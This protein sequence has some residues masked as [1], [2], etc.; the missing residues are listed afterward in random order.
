MTRRVRVLCA[1][2]VSAFLAVSLPAG[3][4]PSSPEELAAAVAR[5]GIVL[6]TVDWHGWVRD[7]QTGEVF[8]GSEG[9]TVKVTCSGA[10]IDPDGYVATASHCVHTGP[11]GGAGVL[12]D[13]ALT[14]LAKA[15]RVGDP[16]KAKQTLTDHAVAE[17]GAPDRPVDRQIQ[18][19]R[20]VPD[21]NGRKRDVAP[22][23][24]ADLVAPEDGDVAVLKVARSRLPAVQLRPDA[25]PVGT[26]VLAIGYPGSV[27]QATDPNLEPSNK[28]GQISA[29]R[30]QQGR[31][32]Y[33]FSAAATHGMSGGPVVDTQGRIVGL[34]SQASP[35]ETQS[36]NFAS[37]SST[38]LDVLHGKGIDVETSPADKDYRT[39]LDR[40]FDGDY[41][42]AVASFDKALAG[43]PSHTQAA[44][45]RRKA[46]EQG[47]SP[48]GG[49][50]LL[51]T[52]A[53]VCAAVGLIAGAAGVAWTVA[54]RRK[55]RLSSNMDTPPYGIP[56][57]PV[58]LSGQPQPDRQGDPDETERRD[59]ALGDDKTENQADTGDTDVQPRPPLAS[60]PSAD[61]PDDSD[62]SEAR[63]EQEQ[64]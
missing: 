48:G 42:A 14:E 58:G 5:P 19:E 54:G 53:I 38:V 30:T 46:I 15:G 39:G 26:P 63:T 33:E 16:G 62:H 37:A 11:S 47:G 8:G 22:A 44:E 60:E 45:Y 4:Q 57:L 34:I 31:P 35:G 64:R 40:Y 18:V 41:D 21:G 29:H 23:T 49:T 32:F 24:V 55:A 51:V 12:F 6:V 10:V 36:F 2:S 9:Y 61:E 17:G 3:A 28:N 50:T 1:A 52:F 56:L 25:P 43:A 59:G 13:A 20:M 7:K 27:D